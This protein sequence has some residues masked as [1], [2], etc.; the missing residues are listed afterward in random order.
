MRY[1]DLIKSLLKYNTKTKKQLKAKPIKHQN[2][3]LERTLEYNIAKEPQELTGE[4]VAASKNG[5]FTIIND[6]CTEIHQAKH[7]D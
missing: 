6:N 1:Q 2:N 3:Y 4:F 5:Y 7:T